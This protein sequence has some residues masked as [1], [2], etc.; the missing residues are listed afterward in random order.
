MPIL[1]RQ[2]KSVTPVEVRGEQTS[3]EK[4]T[5]MHKFTNTNGS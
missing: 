5:S 1:P 2:Q 4:L 3:P